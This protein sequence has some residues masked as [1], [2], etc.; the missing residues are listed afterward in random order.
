MQLALLVLLLSGIAL[1]PTDTVRGTIG[2]VPLLLAAP[3]WHEQ[4]AAAG[5]PPAPLITLRV[6]S[7]VPNGI[8]DEADWFVRHGLALP[9]MEV[10]NPFLG[11]PDDGSWPF[12]TSYS[13]CIL[14]R[15]IEQPD[16]TFLIYGRDFSEGRYL[17][18]LDPAT[19]NIRYFLDFAEWASSP[20]DV[21]VDRD[22]ISQALVWADERDGVLYVSHSHRTYAESSGGLNGYV[23][24]LDPASGNI[25]W[26]SRP[27][28]CNSRNFEIVEQSI[29]CG[30]GF[31]AEPD[32]VYVLDRFTGAVTNR[33]KVKSAPSFLVTKGDRLFVRCYDTDYVFSLSWNN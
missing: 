27:L 10:P 24:A 14:V 15:A 26:R 33:T 11:R 5:Q 1:G 12:P 22:F 13:D 7:S 2:P 21:P 8:I 3:P 31:T 20:G 6:L 19:R 30:Y 25:I 4:L 29:V 23:T 16:A 28:V 17:L 32:Y 9:A 18:A